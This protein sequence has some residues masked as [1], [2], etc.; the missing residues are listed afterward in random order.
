M[1]I[2]TSFN[3][4]YLFDRVSLST[5][6]NL[7]HICTLHTYNS[8]THTYIYIVKQ[9]IGLKL[10]LIILKSKSS[11]GQTCSCQCLNEFA[12]LIRLHFPCSIC[13]KYLPSHWCVSSQLIIKLIFSPN[14]IFLRLTFLARLKCNVS[15]ASILFTSNL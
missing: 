15:S 9:N 7:S 5:S 3:H 8:N 10:T 12:A 14:S 1:I 2:F 11:T 6:I 4:H 13:M